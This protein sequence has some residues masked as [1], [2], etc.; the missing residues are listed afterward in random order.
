MS[1]IGRNEPCPCGSG[2]K[3]KHC[4]GDG[5][6]TAVAQQAANLVMLR[7]IA[8]E[9]YKREMIDQDEFRTILEQTEY[10]VVEFVEEPKQE[11]EEEQPEKKVSD[12]IEDTGLSRCGCGSGYLVSK[13]DRCF[14]CKN[15]GGNLD[16]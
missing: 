9:K 12:I 6:K 2:L 7:L 13:G 11:E 14:K 8:E 3:F 1:K 16:G 4:H 10:K 5:K 15:N